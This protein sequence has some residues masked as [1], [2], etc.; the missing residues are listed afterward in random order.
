M[1]GEVSGHTQRIL[2]ARVN[3][4]MNSMLFKVDQISGCCHKGFMTCF[5]RA[6]SGRGLKAVEGRVFEP[7]AVYGRRPR[8]A[9]HAQKKFTHR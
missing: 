5:Y 1:K 7:S 2:E 3:C 4:E 8:S 6:V 9:T